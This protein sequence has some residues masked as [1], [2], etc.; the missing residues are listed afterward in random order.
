VVEPEESYFVQQL[1]DRFGM[2]RRMSFLDIQIQGDERPGCYLLP[3]FQGLLDD[4]GCT[5]GKA[6]K[7]RVIGGINLTPMVNQ[8]SDLQPELNP[9]PPRSSNPAAIGHPAGRHTASDPV[10]DRICMRIRYVS[11]GG[12][13]HDGGEEQGRRWYGVAIHDF[14]FKWVPSFVPL[15]FRTVPI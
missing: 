2:L 3:S 12:I 1:R 13:C 6:L 8:R 7:R 14:L 10:C 11:S 15:G 4:A 9:V 5:L